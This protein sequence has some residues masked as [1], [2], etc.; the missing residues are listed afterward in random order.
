[1]RSPLACDHD[2]VYLLEISSRPWDLQPH[3][4]LDVHLKGA[5]HPSHANSL[6]AQE[7]GRDHA[8]LYA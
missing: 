6:G 7:Q 4:C 3:L 2:S 1:M 5:V 8:D